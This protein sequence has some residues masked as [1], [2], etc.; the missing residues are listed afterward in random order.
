MGK[1]HMNAM[2][3]TLGFRNQTA[4]KDTKGHTLETN[5]MDVMHARKDF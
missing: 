5:L 1:N 2:F 3:V 4:L